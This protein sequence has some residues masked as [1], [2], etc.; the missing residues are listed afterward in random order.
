[1]EKEE[2]QISVIMAAYNAENTIGEAIESVI[3]QSHKQ[4][5]LIVVND[6]STDCTREIVEKYAMCEQRIK[7]VDNEENMGVS[8]TRLAAVQKAKY[9]WI[10]ILDSD[11]AW[12]DCKLEKQICVAKNKE[13]DI[14]YTGSAFMEDDSSQKEWILHVP[15]HVTYKQLLRQNIISNSSAMVKKSVYSD[16]YVVGDEMHEDFALWLM[17]LKNGAVA[18]GVDEPLLI[19]RLSTHSKTSNKLI[20]ARMNWNTYRYIGLNVLVRWYYMFR[21]MTAG[22]KKYKNLK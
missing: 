11:D 16:N 4:W 10:A 8:K 20:S 19:Y 2:F 7:L 18:Y 13:A 15:E 5:E 21:Y 22:V 12:A 3:K 9:D 14:V 6:C 17:A 1:M